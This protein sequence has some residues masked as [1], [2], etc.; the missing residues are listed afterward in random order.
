MN[1]ISPLVSSY[2]TFHSSQ[3][4]ELEYD[5]PFPPQS[6]IEKEDIINIGPN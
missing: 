2:P 5:H 1:I 3:H 6:A 4:N